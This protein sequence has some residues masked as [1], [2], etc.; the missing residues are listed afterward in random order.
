MVE[1]LKT[2]GIFVLL[3]LMMLLLYGNLTLG[4]DGDPLGLGDPEKAEI[5]MASADSRWPLVPT[6]LALGADGAYYVPLTQGEWGLL[7]SQ[8][9]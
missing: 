8:A 9:E 2:A 3:A 7:L 1:R 4:M 6:L 5:A